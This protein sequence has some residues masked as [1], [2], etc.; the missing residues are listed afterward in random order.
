MLALE[1][2]CRMSTVVFAIMD[3]VEDSRCR[4]LSPYSYLMID[5]SGPE[6]VFIL[7]D[8]YVLV[9][10]CSKHLTEQ[11]PLDTKIL[12]ISRRQ[13]VLLILLKM[14]TMFSIIVVYILSVT[15]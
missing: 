7:A 14:T 3:Y 6:D 2:I 15:D 4:T 12:W 5:K 8:T 9:T 1:R 11:I 13:K 10:A